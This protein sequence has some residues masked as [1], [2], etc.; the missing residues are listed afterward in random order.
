MKTLNQR[1][2]KENHLKYIIWIKLLTHRI[3]EFIRVRSDKEFFRKIAYKFVKNYQ[4]EA[5]EGFAKLKTFPPP[6]PKFTT[7]DTKF[8]NLLVPDFNLA[9]HVPNKESLFAQLEEVKPAN[10]TPEYDFMNTIKKIMDG[11]LI[12]FWKA[13]QKK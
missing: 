4:R 8:L 13:I 3:Y 7:E 1:N 9:M 2:S 5:K 11:K 6:I 12:N 10:N